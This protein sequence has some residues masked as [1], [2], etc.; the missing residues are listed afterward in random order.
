MAHLWVRDV[1]GEWAVLP[2]VADAFSLDASPPRLAGGSEGCAAPGIVLTR[3][4]VAGAETW[5]LLSVRAGGVRVNGVP[6]TLGV[7]VVADRD[8]IWV[9][10]AGTFYFSAETLARVAPLPGTERTLYCPRCKLGVEAGSPAVRC[11]QCGVWYHGSEELPC[12]GYA[13]TCALCPQP[14]DAGAGFR[15]TPEGL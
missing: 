3:A 8:E 12:W 1:S 4:G 10:G 7:R 6:L 15:W 5:V 2:L 14:T 13:E 11:P 9:D